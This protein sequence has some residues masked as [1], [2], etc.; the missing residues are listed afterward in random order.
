MTTLL[1]NFTLSSNTSPLLHHTTPTT[2]HT[3]QHKT[4]HVTDQYSLGASSAI[5]DVATIGAIEDA[6]KD[7]S[8]WVLKPQREGGGNNLYGV[9]LSAFLMKNREDPVLSGMIYSILCIISTSASSCTIYI[10]IKIVT[11]TILTIIRFTGLVV[12]LY[13]VCTGYVLM[14]RIF[15]KPQV[16]AFLR[17]GELLVLPSISE[18]GVYGVF[19]GDGAS[20]PLLNSCAGYLVR[21]KPDG[22]DEGGVAAGYSV[23]S[24]VYLTDNDAKDEE[25]IE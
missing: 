21:T 7:G 3:S 9:E 12:M 11:T 13:Y 14:Q 17:K 2:P 19:L 24:S 1:Y 20:E 25:Q 10:I 23:L 5:T 16:T 18:L 4:T 6:I 8:N 22:V 15:P